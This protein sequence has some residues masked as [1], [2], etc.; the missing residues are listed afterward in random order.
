MAT[1]KY[2]VIF[3]SEVGGHFDAHF[4]IRTA[5]VSAS[6]TTGTDGASRPSPSAIATV[7]SNNNLQNPK[8]GA[9]T[10]IDNCS[11]LDRPSAQTV[12]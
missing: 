2:R 6:D 10:V 8:S 1:L 11:N 4:G 7:L 12:S 5:L 3:H 9:V